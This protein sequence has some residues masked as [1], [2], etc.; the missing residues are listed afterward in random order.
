MRVRTALQH[1]I[2]LGMAIFPV[3][4]V[5]RADFTFGEPRNL[6]PLVNS[7]AD[8]APDCVSH[9]GLEL[10]FDSLRP[11]GYGSWDLWVTKRAT[12]DE[13][14]GVPENLGPLVN[15]AGPDSLAYLSA[16]G[17]ELYFG[18][19]DRPGGYGNGDLWVTRR[20]TREAAWSVPENLG[21]AVNSPAQ[22]GG[23]WISP[24]G[25]ELYFG[26]KR[27]GGYGSEDI[28][29]S[30][31]P[32]V[33]DPW[34]HA[35]N[36]GPVVNSRASEGL[37]G[38]SPDGLL[39]LFSE[40]YNAPLRPGGHGSID[41]WYTRRTSASDPWGPPVNL[42]P[43]VNTASMESGARLSSDGL[44][45]YFGSGRP[46]GYGGSFGWGDIYAAPI[47]PITDFDGDGAVDAGDMSIMVH[48][49][50]QGESLCDVGPMPWGD[51]VVDIEDLI[52]LAQHLGP[53]LECAAHWRLDEGGGTI[54]SD[55]VGQSDATVLGDAT[56][57]PAEGIVDGALQFDGVDD[58]L[59][60]D[61]V[62]DPR[63]G[64]IRV[65]CWV[66]SDVAGGVIVSQTPGAS[67]GSP[68]LATDPSDGTL[69]SGMMFPFPGL[70]S[71][72]VVADGQWHEVT[73]EWD[74]TYRRLWVDHQEV[75]RDATP[76][77][78]PPLS[79]NG[80][81]VIGAGE[82]FEVGTFF[83]GLI[84]DVRVYNRAVRP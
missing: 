32:T 59:A 62:A 4:Q 9:D 53:G 11:G 66:K 65:V 63:V 54:A 40:D 50:G 55:S 48:H 77:A 7:V 41:M 37:L 73:A 71:R 36:L 60:T 20:A 8:E 34:G 81:L 64:P 5:A 78:R 18:S 49:W 51:G 26:S 45:L 83:T 10:Y 67:V 43:V 19:G 76:M 23:P 13:A 21:P 56:W 12:R 31:R 57:L 72:A 69:M 14:W 25:L 28:W 58:C 52:V 6:G 24:G 79:W 44:T 75:S 33:D 80:T 70:P 17:L 39:L 1:L 29:V 22:E 30:R 2:L 38:M 61:F 35:T 3:S 27:E 68:W 47:I 46:G 15:T 16:D 84:D 82:R 74:G 42:G